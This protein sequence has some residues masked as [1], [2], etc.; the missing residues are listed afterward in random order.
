MIVETL[1]RAILYSLIY[2][3]N[4]LEYSILIYLFVFLTSSLAVHELSGL[5]A[6]TIILQ[7]VKNVDVWGCFEEFVLY[8]LIFGTLVVG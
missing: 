4:F 7:K 6:Y 2:E 3:L 1:Q 8:Y 5:A